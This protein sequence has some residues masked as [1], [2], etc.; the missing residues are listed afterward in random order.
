MAP[1]ARAVSTDPRDPSQNPCRVGT[2]GWKG[3]GRDERRRVVQGDVLS[4]GLHK[5]PHNV[6][7]LLCCQRLLRERLQ[8]I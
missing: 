1:K 7:F 4:C 5:H 3:L 2:G 6:L 8:C